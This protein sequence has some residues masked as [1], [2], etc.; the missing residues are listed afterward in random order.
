M[1]APRAAQH[2][3][4]TASSGE[5]TVDRGLALTA[6]AVTG[7]V[8]GAGVAAI[9]VDALYLFAALVGCAFIVRDFRIGVVLLIV[10]LPV[11]RSTV[12]PHEMMG[13]TGLNPLNVV[14]AAT[15]A[16]CALR[17]AFDGTLK[18]LAPRSLLLYYM[19]PIVVG[20]ILGAR[21]VNEIAPELLRYN[22]VDFRDAAGYLAEL[23]AKPLMLP[24]FGLL[25]GAAVARS[26]KPQRF[27][28][29]MLISIWIISLVVIVYVA[30][31]GIGLGYLA[32]A[33]A[34]EFLSPL[35][36]HANELGRLSAVCFAL[37][38]F[39]LAETPDVRL[40]TLLAVSVALVLLA[41]MLTFSRSAFVGVV[42]VA[43]LYVLWRRS[44]RTLGA[45]VIALAIGFLVMP[46]AVYDRITEGFGEGLNAISAGRIE[47]LWL[48]LLPE[49]LRSPVWGNGLG[50]IMWSETMRGL[51]GTSVLLVT[52]PH[53]AYLEAA[54]DVG[55]GG[56]LLLCVYFVSV[57]REFSALARDPALNPTLRGFFVGAMAALVALAI[58]NI[59]DSSLLPRPEQTFLWFAIGMMYGLRARLEAP[60]G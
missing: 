16:A 12:F 51:G 19:L 32:G 20:G 57:Y 53:N 58:V 28:L 35:G 21:H 6:L 5:T 31:S 4:V 22:A 54:L 15:L 47:G 29:P 38:L 56:L 46:D 11:S 45:G 33:E 36:L 1:P 8:F 18:R 30:G 7:A 37:L 34:R 24:V 14:F 42:L 17:T 40:R 41:L 2:V 49:V 27:L 48:P 59:A 9:G 39:T 44:L 52:H 55:V 60:A 50:S 3:G 25:V 43:G 10:L 23:V 13:I 26:A